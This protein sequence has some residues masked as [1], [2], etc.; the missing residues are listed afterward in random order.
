VRAIFFDKTA[1]TNWSLA[2]HQDRTGN[3]IE[4]ADSAEGMRLPWNEPDSPFRFNLA[5]ASMM[6]GL[7][8][9]GEALGHRVET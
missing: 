1:E 7:G 3:C 5:T 8:P 6:I 2:L 9:Y 4:H